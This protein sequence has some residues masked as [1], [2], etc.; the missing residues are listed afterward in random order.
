MDVNIDNQNC[1]GCG[2]EC[3][4]WFC[5]EGQCLCDGGL[6]ECDGE[7]VDVGANADNCGGCGNDCDLDLQACFDGDCACLP[8]TT[9]CNGECI[10]TSIDPLNCGQCGND[11]ANG[12][13][14]S[15]GEC[16][17]SCDLNLPDEC[18]NGCTNPGVECTL[19]SCVL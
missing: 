11:C 7:C 13:L 14:C 16:Q 5:V 15:A 8:G 6:L 18:D 2:S 4:V 10:N 12:L 19:G 3:Q 1:G 9:Q 17:I